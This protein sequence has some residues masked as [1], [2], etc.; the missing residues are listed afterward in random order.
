MAGTAILLRAYGRCV[1]VL[2]PGR[3]VSTLDKDGSMMSGF[4]TSFAAP[5]VSGVAAMHMERYGLT[6]SPG[7]I[8]GIIK[9]AGTV[10]VITGFL[11]GAPNLLLYNSVPRRRACC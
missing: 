2:A 4:G 1:D 6:N 7:S 8:E 10:G 5:L 9:D 11:Y 3:F